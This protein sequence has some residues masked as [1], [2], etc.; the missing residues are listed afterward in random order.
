MQKTRI[1]SAALAFV[2]MAFV[3]LAA[4][5]AAAQTGYDLS[6]LTPEVRAAAEQARAAAA[7]AEAAA[8]TAREMAVRARQAAERAQQGAPG[9]AVR[10]LNGRLG[11][12][13]V[14]GEYNGSQFQGLAVDVTVDGASL[15]DLY[16]G[17]WVNGM[18]QGLGVY[19]YSSNESNVSGSLR[20]EG[21]NERGNAHGDGVYTWQ[22]TDVYAGGFVDNLKSGYGVYTYNDE[23]GGR[24]E[25]Q[26][27]NDNRHGYGV[28]WDAQGQVHSAGQW[29]D[30]QFVS[31][32]GSTA[33]A[34]TLT[35]RAA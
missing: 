29:R 10:L 18:S 33:K 5:P 6:Q 32:D 28:Y 7:R 25:G 1:A 3:A 34:I 31:G 21:Y 27:A 11:H 9:T 30:D 22:D 2:A 14:H 23:T 17:Q 16:A 26:W 24:Y 8:V 15:G 35:K 19:V 13:Y 20:H 4:A 12:R